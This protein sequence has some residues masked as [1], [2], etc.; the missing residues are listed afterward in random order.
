MWQVGTIGGLLAIWPWAA[1]THPAPY[2]PVLQN[3][4]AGYI[5]LWHGDLLMMAIVPSVVRLAIGFLIAVVVGGVLGLVLGYLRAFDPWMRP[6]LEYL[7]FI[8]AVA[9]LPAAL[10]LFG[11][12]DTM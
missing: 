1:V 3:V 12:T 2:L 11:P 7:R 5:R 6:V 8:P 9:I 10:L 4:V